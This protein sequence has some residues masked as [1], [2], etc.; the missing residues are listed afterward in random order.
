MQERKD[1]Y[2]QEKTIVNEKEEK[3][4]KVGAEKKNTHT[5]ST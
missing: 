3:K 5:E 1:L 2:L 4:K